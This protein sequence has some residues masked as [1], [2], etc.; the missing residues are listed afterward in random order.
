MRGQTACLS[1][2]PLGLRSRL[3]DLNACYAIA[4]HRHRRRRRH[5]LLLRSA[6][7]IAE[8]SASFCQ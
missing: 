2:N 4:K 3:E 8:V 5:Y 1:L 7:T 6:A